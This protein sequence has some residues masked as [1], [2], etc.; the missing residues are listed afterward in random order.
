[1]G[2]RAGA[3]GG[4]L[5]AGHVCR[6]KCNLLAAPCISATDMCLA[7][8]GI[9]ANAGLPSAEAMAQFDTAQVLMQLDCPGALDKRC[10]KWDYVVQLHVCSDPATTPARPVVGS[11]DAHAIE[12]QGHSHASCNV[13]V[14]RWVTAYGRPGKWL[15]DASAV[16]PVLRAGGRQHFVLSQPAWSTQKYRAVSTLIL[17]NTGKRGVPTASLDLFSGGA[18]DAQYNRR[19]RP[20][21]VDIPPRTARAEIHSF[22]TGHG[23]GT[24]D[25]NCAEFCETQHRFS[26]RA[27][28]DVGGETMVS[29]DAALYQ[30][31]LKDAGSDL[32]C[33]AQVSCAALHC[34]YLAPLA[35]RQSIARVRR[36]RQSP[37]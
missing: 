9:Y 22:I 13:E 24:D 3:G 34:A 31:T 5:V 18:F 37:H 12:Q 36:G 14:G 28:V 7:G 29:Q 23:W 20:V 27:A 4:R 21:L 6:A 16:L 25:A 19:H 11:V 17:S 32:G 35:C 30:H 8:R 10:G 1:M 33:A 2:G 26:V 15:S